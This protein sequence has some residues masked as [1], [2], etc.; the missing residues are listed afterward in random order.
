MAQ[1]VSKA[2]PKYRRQKRLSGRHVAFVEVD[3]NRH[4]LGP[5]SSPESRER[6]ARLLAERAA[7]GGHLPVTPEEITIAELAAQFWQHA[8]RYYRRPDGTPTSELSSLRYALRPLVALH[9]NKRVGEFG[10][11]ALKTVRGRMLQSGWCRSHI[12]KSVSRVKHKFRWG[13]ENEL[14]P[15]AY[16]SRTHVYTFR[17]K[18]PPN[19]RGYEA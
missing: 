18:I 12:N 15:Q 2:I 17:A 11:R 9:G 19:L 7:H 4:Y 1:T 14:A 10:P 5:Y 16:F 13:T 3:G 8:E 6:Y